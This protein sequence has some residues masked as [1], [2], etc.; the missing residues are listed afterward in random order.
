MS[1]LHAGTVAI[2]VEVEGAG[3]DVR[4][5]VGEACTCVETQC[6]APH[7]APL[8]GIERGATVNE[9]PAFSST[10]PAR[11]TQQEDTRCI[12]PVGTLSDLPDRA[13]HI[14]DEKHAR[15][16]AASIRL[17]VGTWVNQ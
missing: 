3:T 8:P 13:L 16:S 10:L 11:G 9:A 4:R 12:G 15:G 2:D 14:V 5:G 6:A 17:E 7:V 1:N